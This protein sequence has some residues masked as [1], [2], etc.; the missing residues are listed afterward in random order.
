MFVR[1]LIVHRM[2]SR[3]H[4]MFH[5]NLRVLAT[6]TRVFETPGYMHITRVFFFFSISVKK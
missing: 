4:R 5:Q 2:V 1:Y 3:L 6:S